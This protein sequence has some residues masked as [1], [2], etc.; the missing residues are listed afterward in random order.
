M[1][2]FGALFGFETGVPDSL[3]YGL[4]GGLGLRKAGEEACRGSVSQGSDQKKA[5]PSTRTPDSG[6][7]ALKPGADWMWV[8]WGLWWLRFRFTVRGLREILN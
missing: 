6:P 5:K 3:A 1:F 7:Q 4:S 8:F 2:R